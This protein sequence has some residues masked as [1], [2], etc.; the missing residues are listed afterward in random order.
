MSMDFNFGTPA[1]RNMNKAQ[2]RSG[3]I[4]QLCE[5][6]KYE[7]QLVF[8]LPKEPYPGKVVRVVAEQAAEMIVDNKARLATEKESKE[9][10]MEIEQA[11]HNIEKD[12]AR[13]DLAKAVQRVMKD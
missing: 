10:E 9:Y 11:K 3:K 5:K 2:V 6:F 1:N 7:D 4:H 8:I 13:T 12:I